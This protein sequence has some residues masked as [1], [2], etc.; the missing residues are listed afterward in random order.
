[1][2]VHLFLITIE[3]FLTLKANFFILVLDPINLFINMEAR[4]AGAEWDR[5][6]INEVGG[7]DRGQKPKGTYILRVVRRHLKNLSKWWY[8]LILY[9]WVRK[10][11]SF[12]LGI[13]S[14]YT[15]DL[16]LQDFVNG[17][18]CR[19][20]AESRRPTMAFTRACAWSSVNRSFNIHVS[21][22]PLFI[23]NVLRVLYD[24]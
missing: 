5:V 12:D 6:V 21:V 17:G 20:K 8:S 15:S 9:E 10:V 1:M 13:L 3:R 23:S 11:D 2:P 14:S 16:F 4:V 7:T 19:R 18:G 22:W 24:A